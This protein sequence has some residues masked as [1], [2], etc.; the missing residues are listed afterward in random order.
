M[1]LKI[2]PLFF[3]LFVL[4]NHAL[5]SAPVVTGLSLFSGPSS[6]GTQVEVTGSGFT[7]ATEVQF[8]ETLA[9]FSVNSD[10]SL[11]AYSPIH[12]PESIFVTVT[13]PE[14]TS[15]PTENAYFVYL[16]HWQ[17]YVGNRIGLNVTVIDA[18]TD[19]VTTIPPAGVFGNPLSIGMTPDGTKAFV[20]N[21]TTVDNV[22]VIDTATNQVTF[23]P[24]APGSDPSAVAVTPDGTKAYVANFLG[25]DVSVIIVADESATTINTAESSPIAVAITPN[26]AK[27]Y[28]SNFGDGVTDIL[29]VD[30]SFTTIP[31]LG[32]SPSAIAIT[33][34]GT[35]AYVA[36]L[37]DDN[38]AVIN[39]ADDSFITIPV[40]TTGPLSISLAITPDGQQVYVANFGDNSVAVIRTVDNSVTTVPTIGV[41]PI[42]VAIT[43]DGQKAYVCNYLSGDVAV[44]NTTDL[45]FTTIPSVGTNPTTL[46]ITPDGEKVYVANQG[47]NTVAIIETATDT[48]VN[49]LP[50]GVA[51]SSMN[52][53]PDQAPLARFIATLAPSGSAS[54][55][56]A[57]SSI[58]PVGTIAN[59][60]WN[61]GDGTT[62]KTSS[63]TVSHTYLLPGSYSVTLT[64]TNSA[65]TSTF[66]LFNPASLVILEPSVHL[67][68]G[69]NYYS[70][71]NNGGPSATTTQTL[72]ILSPLPI[73]R[74][75]S[76]NSSQVCGGISVEITGVNFTGATQVLF[77]SVPATRFVV[78]SDQLIT[79]VVPPGKLGTVNVRVITPA[80]ESA[81][82]SADEFTYLPP[83][84]PREAKVRQVKNQFATQTDL[85][86][87]L[88][89]KAPRGN[90][91]P[92][93]YRIYRDQALTRL[94][95]TIPVHDNFRLKNH[96][97]HRVLAKFAHDLCQA[98]PSFR[99]EDHHRKKG[100][101]YHY[102]IVSVDREGNLSVPVEVTIK[103]ERRQNI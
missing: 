81:V 15:S 53:T 28:I 76:P 68:F 103:R 50:T 14:G 102:F 57:F 34:D 29:T 9:L 40:G 36:L 85:I 80:G 94:V 56:D 13:T 20:T 86:N 4:M 52:I 49:S 31:S 1:K 2:F 11:T 6:G 67:P 24:F 97:R 38:V 87:L 35:K 12:S 10:T 93:A 17:I 74:G 22:G 69:Y 70:F 45:T 16:G 23:I 58:S 43:P 91:P 8:G 27:A 5:M 44:I 89:W 59:Y 39:T 46:V 77:G 101:T 95:A 30:N 55:F 60:S 61:F 66:Q 82:T 41:L 21:G 71:T 78:N 51:P 79:A 83:L 98:G 42:A 96:S 100:K 92:V 7:G 84:P 73:I 33:P 47:D 63:P 26:S 37:L 32:D 72:T 64:V 65:G 48:V 88:S 62:L 54:F 90:C 19:S 18:T 25:N 75:I 3:S 99:F